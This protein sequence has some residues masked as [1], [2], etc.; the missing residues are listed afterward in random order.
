M[1][2]SLSIVAK[3]SPA[4]IQALVV[5]LFSTEGIADVVDLLLLADRPVCIGQLREVVGALLRRGFV[6]LLLQNGAHMGEHTLRRHVAG[7]NACIIRIKVCDVARMRPREVL[8]A[9]PAARRPVA[10]PFLYNGVEVLPSCTLDR[11][12]VIVMARRTIGGIYIMVH[13]L[14]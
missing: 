8:L 1:T 7:A 10:V 13:K 2:L 6:D 11:R 9:E 3:G 12:H 5:H 14:D 4:E